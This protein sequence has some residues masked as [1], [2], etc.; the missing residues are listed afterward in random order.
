MTNYKKEM[1][2]DFEFYFKYKNNLE[3]YLHFSK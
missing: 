3:I 1:K 2:S